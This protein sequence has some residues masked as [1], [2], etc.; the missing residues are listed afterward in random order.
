MAS[1]NSMIA[2][3]HALLTGGSRCGVG[4]A[5]ALALD[6]AGAAKSAPMYKISRELWD[7]M[8]AINLKSVITVN[9]IRPGYTDTPI[10]DRSL[11]NIAQ[12]TGMDRTSARKTLASVNPQERIICPAEV[13]GTI[14]WLCSDSAH[15]VTARSIV[16]ASGEIM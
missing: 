14:L 10:L 3:T 2:N 6:A 1:E 11:D 5:I 16:I 4:R 12:A 7:Q 15:G 9:A 8:R 13:A